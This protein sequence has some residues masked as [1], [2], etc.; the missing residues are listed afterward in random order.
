MPSWADVGNPR[1]PHKAA[2][3]NVHNDW[4]LFRQIRRGIDPDSHILCVT[5]KNNAI[6]HLQ[7]IRQSVFADIFMLCFSGDSLFR[8]NAMGNNLIEL[9]VVFI[10]GICSRFHAVTV[11]LLCL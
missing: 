9:Q 2:A 4:S 3:M 5:A 8:F 1:S 11:F 6:L 7:P 10:S